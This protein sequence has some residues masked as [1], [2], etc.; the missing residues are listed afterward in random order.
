MGF[1]RHQKKKKKIT[2]TAIFFLSTFLDNDCF[3]VGQFS[4]KKEKHPGEMRD[5]RD[6]GAKT[7]SVYQPE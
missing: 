1:I 7:V 2:H 5:S 3:V 4:E 6:H